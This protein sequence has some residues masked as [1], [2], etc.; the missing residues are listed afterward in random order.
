MTSHWDAMPQD[1]CVQNPMNLPS[2]LISCA[3]LLTPT[4]GSRAPRFLSP[5][6]KF[7]TY[8]SIPCVECP[9]YTFQEAAPFSCQVLLCSS[10]RFP[11]HSQPLCRPPS[12]P[13]SQSGHC[14]QFWNHTHILPSAQNYRPLPAVPASSSSS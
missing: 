12:C 2:R 5:C 7:Q 11:L 13:F 1:P 9:S 4:H 6:L 10:L 14:F 3:H 8:S